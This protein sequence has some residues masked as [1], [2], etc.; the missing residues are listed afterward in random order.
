MWGKFCR[1]VLGWSKLGGNEVAL[2]AS[3]R[4]CKKQSP[5]YFGYLDM[6]QPTPPPSSENFS[7]GQKSNLPKKSAL[8]PTTHGWTS[9]INKGR[10]HRKLDPGRSSNFM[11]A[12]ALEDEWI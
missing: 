8:Q 11:D 1:S 5:S 4:C 3:T 9:L 10:V 6:D 2:T 12:E 7:S